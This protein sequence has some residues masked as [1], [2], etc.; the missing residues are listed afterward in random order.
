MINLIKQIPNW[1]SLNRDEIAEILNT[2]SIERT[3]SQLYTYAGIIDKVGQVAGFAFRA[4]VR[5]LAA[6]GNPA[7]LPL[8]L[9]EALNFAHERLIGGGLDLSRTEVQSTLDAAAAIPQLEPFV[10]AVKSI[11][12]FLVTPLQA[13]GFPPATEESVAAAIDADWMYT[14]RQTRLD[15]AADRLQAYREAIAAWDGT[16][17]EPVL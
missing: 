3:D 12:R 16:G 15:A 1:D 17:E 6:E 14:A 7:S 11:G 9:F 10:P 13:A 4:T 8:E 2:P 5:T